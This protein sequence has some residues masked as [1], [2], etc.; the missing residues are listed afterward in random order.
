MAVTPTFD[1]PVIVR[2]SSLNDY[3]DCARRSAARLFE[4]DVVAAGFTL[5]K[6]KMGVAAFI[7]TAVHKGAEV[8]ARDKLHGHTPSLSTGTDAAVEKLHG[9]VIEEGCDWDDLSKTPAIAEKQVQKMVRAYGEGV[10]PGIQPV[11]IEER[12]EAHIT[13]R[14]ILSGQK[15]QSA[16]EPNALH[17]TKTGARMRTYTP[18]I[19]GYA[20]IEKA[21]GRSI[22][23][24]IIDFIQRVP[25][26]K[27]Q[28][29]PISTPVPLAQAE[30]AAWAVAKA[31]ERDI[32][33]F[34]FGDDERGI[35]IGDPWSFLANPNSP[36]C[37]A[38]WC[39]AH[40]TPFCVEH[41]KD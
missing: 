41:R 2:C 10:L 28:P 29:T 33:T 7:G 5:R 19:G 3:P 13:P 1:D 8:M 32:T 31:M 40:S 39:P 20:A 35:R 37:S 36:F 11:H 26:H 16:R 25:V 15:D 38:R 18:Q 21:H 24:G 27:E 22:E 4:V 12:M 30:A 9:Q 34:R 23:M 14:L 6:T 17:D